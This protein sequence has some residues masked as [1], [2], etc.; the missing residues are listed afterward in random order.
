[1]FH[2]RFRLVRLLLIVVGIL[3]AA[4]TYYGVL[5]GIG[6]IVSSVCIGW[7]VHHPSSPYPYWNLG[8]G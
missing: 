7:M 3:V 1:M 6:I 4:F 2:R 5:I 8:K